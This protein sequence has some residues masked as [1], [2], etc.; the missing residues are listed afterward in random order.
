MS[1]LSDFVGGI[2]G[3]SQQKAVKKA[4]NASNKKS[5]QY[6]TEALDALDKGNVDLA[7]LIPFVQQGKAG[8]YS[9]IAEMLKAI[10][11]EVN[12]G[13]TD[14]GSQFDAAIA[15]AS[16]GDAASRAAIE[17]QFLDSIRTGS[18]MAQKS[19]AGTGF[20]NSSLVPSKIA[21]AV[22]PNAIGGKMAALAKLES[23][24]NARLDELRR[25]KVAALAG[26]QNFASEAV[27]NTLGKK[28]DL[29]QTYFGTELGLRKE[30]IQNSLNVKAQPGVVYPDLNFPATV[31]GASA[32]GSALGGIGASALGSF[33]NNYF[34]GLG[35]SASG[36][37][38][39]DIVKA[40]LAKQAA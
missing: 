29:G 12:R 1:W 31:S 38:V 5:E 35:S 7:G 32:L 16:G 14:I 9:D 36:N 8:A 26:R 20:G 28:I 10:M 6:R 30:P 33:S 22:L 15:S 18:A 17:Q 24:N 27:T 25:A 11:D 34:G 39:Q 23:D 13:S 40:L 3:Q 4:A 37:G 21:T 2:T 19:V